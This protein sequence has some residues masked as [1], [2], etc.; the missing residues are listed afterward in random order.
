ML[1]RRIDETFGFARSGHVGLQAEDIRVGQV[2]ICRGLGQGV[3]VP[4]AHPDP[5]ALGRQSGRDR[6]SDAAGTPGDDRDFT[7]QLKIH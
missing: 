6:P 3:G 5:A 4:S 7:G 1:G 2:E